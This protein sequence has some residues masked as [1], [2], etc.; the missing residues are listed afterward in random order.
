VLGWT[1]ELGNDQL[2]R[3]YVHV[4]DQEGWEGIRLYV[5]HG[6]ER[7]D[8]AAWNLRGPKE[9]HIHEEHL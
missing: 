5:I 6:Y 3:L 2:L 1:T 7:V 4:T 8:R 9:A